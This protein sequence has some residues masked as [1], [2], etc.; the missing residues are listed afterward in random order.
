MRPAAAP[1]ESRSV[2]DREWYQ[3]SRR[4]HGLLE[5]CLRADN[6]SRHDARGRWGCGSL[7]RG[8]GGSSFREDRLQRR[9]S[10]GERE[11]VIIEGP[12]RMLDAW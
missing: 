7:G 12:P 10:G 1:A 4:D 11:R 8:S 3:R 5:R 2:Y 9:Q 6:C